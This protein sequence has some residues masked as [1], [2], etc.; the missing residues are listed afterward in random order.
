MQKTA[1]GPSTA[2][3]F[4]GL[5]MCT[6][7]IIAIP[8]GGTV[9]KG[10][11]APTNAPASQG[12]GKGSV[13]PPQGFQGYPN[14]RGGGGRQKKPGVLHL[15]KTPGKTNCTKKVHRPTW[16]LWVTIRGGEGL[17]YSRPSLPV[18]TQGSPKACKK[19]NNARR[20]QGVKAICFTGPP[21]LADSPDPACDD[22]VVPHGKL[23]NNKKRG[24]VCNNQ[25]RGGE[26]GLVWG[27]KEDKSGG[28]K[29]CYQKN[30][31]K[32]R[33][34]QSEQEKQEQSHPVRSG[35]KGQRTNVK[36]HRVGK[37]E[38]SNWGSPRDFRLLKGGAIKTPWLP[39]GVKNIEDRGEPSN[40]PM[41]LCRECLSPLARET[42]VW[43]NRGGDRDCAREAT[44]HCRLWGGKGR[45]RRE[46]KEDVSG[47][48]ILGGKQRAHVCNKGTP[49]LERERNRE[50]SP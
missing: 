48:A 27:R 11:Y 45:K 24:G 40:I 12:R 36:S 44:P 26:K 10:T 2:P 19:T 20:G 30:P 13:S 15:L 47:R 16:C 49:E 21:Y 37:Q 4:F 39:G 46:K 42:G 8:G 14:Q 3:Q 31:P 1:T 7:G 25:K 5:K 35:G 29:R 41:D 18:P 34:Q 6:P 50:S 33:F 9:F 17:C 23:R 32:P 22:L 28:V 38:V 43:H